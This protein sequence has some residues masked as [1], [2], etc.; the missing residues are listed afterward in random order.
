[1]HGSCIKPDISSQNSGQLD[2]NCLQLQ[3]QGLQGPF[4]PSV[5]SICMFTNTHT[6]TTLHIPHYTHIYHT[7]HTHTHKHTTER[8]RIII[9]SNNYN[10][11][12][13]ENKSEV[14][15]VSQQVWRD[16]EPQLEQYRVF[17][18]SIIARK[19]NT[20]F[21]LRCIVLPL[22]STSVDRGIHPGKEPTK[23][24][25]KQNRML[26]VTDNPGNEEKTR[27]YTYIQT[28]IHTN[29]HTYIHTNIQMYIH[30]NIHTCIHIYVQT[31]THIHLKSISWWT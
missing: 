25:Y 7:L 26:N 15:I 29:V 30:T 17:V 13:L 19:A 22:D 23:V 6:H 8:E 2:H 28:Y 20:E 11:N 5:E 24:T 31:H 4:L 3:F 27:I 1:M 21:W 18:A 9:N 14:P 10:D 12:A 16:V